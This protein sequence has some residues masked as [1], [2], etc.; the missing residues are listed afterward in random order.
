MDGLRGA[1]LYFSPMKLLLLL[2]HRLHSLTESL[3][4]PTDPS[5]AQAVLVP[6]PTGLPP[7]PY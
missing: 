6:H 3:C 4:L 2:Q 5:L 7:S 1:G